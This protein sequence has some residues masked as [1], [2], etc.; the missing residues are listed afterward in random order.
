MAADDLV[1]LATR[2]GLEQSIE[3]GTVWTNRHLP[4][5]RVMARVLEVDGDRIRIINPRTGVESW[6]TRS[7]FV[8]CYAPDA[9]PSDPLDIDGGAA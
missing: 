7:S 2:V 9:G 3:P 5:Q 1:E 6:T 8:L 4:R